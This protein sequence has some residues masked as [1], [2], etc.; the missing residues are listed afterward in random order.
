MT[1]NGFACLCCCLVLAQREILPI[2]KYMFIFCPSF[3]HQVKMMMLK[4]IART[5]GLHHLIIL[6]IYPLFQ[7][8]VQVCIWFLY[9]IFLFF[10]AVEICHIAIRSLINAISPI[11]LLQLSKLVMIWYCI[12]FYIEWINLISWYLLSCQL[13]FH[14]LSLSFLPGASW[15]CWT[16]VQTD[17]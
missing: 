10:W 6:K 2:S 16:F 4:V 7:K 13:S 5:V 3:E 11:Y 15:C 1:D 9:L 14:S 8:Y 12:A 17:S